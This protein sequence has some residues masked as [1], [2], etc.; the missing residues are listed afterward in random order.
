MTKVATEFCGGDEFLETV[1][2]TQN[3]FECQSNITILP[4]D[5]TYLIS[6]GSWE[7]FFSTPSDAMWNLLHAKSFGTHLW[8]S[9]RKNSGV[10]LKSDQ[11][12]YKL[13]EAHCPLTL[14]NLLQFQI[15]K[16]F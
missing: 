6:Y 3:Q 12:V 16:E 7:M 11:L 15:G 8:N 2:L 4:K 14:E 1:S 13:F 10:V 5:V 9:M